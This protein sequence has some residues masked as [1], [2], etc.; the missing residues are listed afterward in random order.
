MQEELSFKNYRKSLMTLFHL[1]LRFA[2]GARVLASLALIKLNPVQM[3]AG[4]APPLIAICVV[5]DLDPAPMRYPFLLGLCGR[6]RL[7][8]LTVVDLWPDEL[9]SVGI[10][11]GASLGHSILKYINDQPIKKP[12]GKTQ[13]PQSASHPNDEG[14]LDCQLH[15]LQRK[16]TY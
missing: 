10:G 5:P 4:S 6:L 12:Q 1:G 7:L 13:P 3:L 14:L 2:S 8:L 16:F 15:P 11:L 9:C